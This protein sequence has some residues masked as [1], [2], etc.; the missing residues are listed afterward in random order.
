MK[1]VRTTW[2]LKRYWG[3]N[4]FFD[5]YTSWSWFNQTPTVLQ[6]CQWPKQIEIFPTEQHGL[7]TVSGSCFGTNGNYWRMWS[8]GR[9]KKDLSKNEGLAPSIYQFVLH[10][11]T[12]LSSIEKRKLREMICL[13][14]YRGRFR[15][16]TRMLDVLFCNI[17]DFWGNWLGAFVLL[18]VISDHYLPDLHDTV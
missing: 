5:F 13:L 15:E 6:R 4:Q 8:K 9:D 11:V 3:E 18:F 2:P 14:H 12:E 7:N 17:Y 1:M 16:S 10:S